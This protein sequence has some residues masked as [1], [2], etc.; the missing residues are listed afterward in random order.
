MSKYLRAIYGP[1]F[2][3]VTQTS[4][5]D[6]D[7]G[8]SL[9]DDT[10]GDTADDQ[11]DAPLGPKG[12][13]ALRAAR[14]E[15][16]SAI[17]KSEALNRQLEA[18]KRNVSP[19]DFQAAQQA[20]EQ[21]Q[22]EAAEK[23]RELDQER[24]RLTTKHQAEL[25]AAND[26]ATAAELKA[27]TKTIEFLTK[28]HF[29]AVGGDNSVDE[30][31]ISSFHAFMQLKGHKHL[32]L[33]D[34]DTVYVVDDSGDELLDDKGKPMPV[35]E[36][37]TRQADSSPVLSRLFK[38]RQGEGSGSRSS[39]GVRSVRGPDLHKLSHRELASVAWPD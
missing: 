7:G 21:A 36:W 8:G 28:E 24:R 18:L 1:S 37:I 23:T 3:C 29:Y 38:P 19:E 27:A 22:R 6:I 32:R 13:Q 35:A 2:H 15:A 17:R 25:K 20:A 10:A 4:P 5:E 39:N 30:S 31:G 16:K 34:D 14:K 33:R 9:D 26:R 11:D 12:E